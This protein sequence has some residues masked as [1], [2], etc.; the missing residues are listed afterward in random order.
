MY[1][2]K[3]LLSIDGFT[4]DNDSFNDISFIHSYVATFH[5]SI[6]FINLV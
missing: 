5:P 4:R 3:V 2:V 6:Y 1:G